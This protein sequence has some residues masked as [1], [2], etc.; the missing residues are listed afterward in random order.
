M[1]KITAPAEVAGWLVKGRVTVPDRVTGHMHRAEITA[2]CMPT[3]RPLTLLHA[4]GGFGKTTLLAECCRAEGARGVPTAWLFLDEQDDEAMLDTYLTF[5]FQRAGLDMAGSFAG[6]AG[7]REA[8]RRIMIALRAI[9]ADGRP[10]VLALDAV[11]RAVNKDGVSVLNELVRA[12]VANLHLALACRQLPV[13]LDIARPVFAGAEVITAG[14]LRFSRADIARFFG[15]RLS[16]QQLAQV[17][18]ESSGWPIALRVERESRGQRNAERAQVV[19]AVVKNWIESRLWCDLSDDDREFVLDAGILEWMDAEL[20]DEALGGQNLMA[21]LHSLPSL[22][23]LLEPVRG[24]ARKVWRLHEL[25]RQHCVS[26]RRR[27]MPGRYRSIHQR[28]AT[29]LARRGETIAAVR[30]AAEAA[31]TALL[32]LILT[33]AGGVQLLLRQGSDQLL[34]ADQSMTEETLALFPRLALVRI[35]ALLVK[36]EIGEAARQLA[37]ARRSLGAAAVDDAQLDCELHSV[38]GMLAQNSCESVGSPGVRRLMAGLA[39]L[40]DRPDVNPL[41]RAAMEYGL[42]MVHNLKAEFD[43]A[44]ERARCARRWIGKEST[45]LNMALDFQYGQVAMARGRVREAAAWYRKGVKA[46]RERFLVDSR[47]GVL[48]EVL[49]RELEL[50][51][52]RFRNEDDTLLPRA[53]WRAS[54]Q[55]ASHASAADMA[56]ELAREARG[57]D[58]A[59]EVAEEMS[60]VARGTGLPQLERYLAGLRVAV[61]AGAGR[62]DDA[63]ARWR[64]HALPESFDRCVDLAGQ[65][66]R[67]ME[68]LSC[69]RLRLCT[70]GGE[71]EAGRRLVGD[72]LA[73]ATQR[74]LRRTQMRALA[75]A[76]AHEHAAGEPDLAAEHLAT[77]LR[78][79]AETDYARPIVRERASAIPLLTRFLDAH[80]ASPL[81]NPATILLAAARAGEQDTVPM[82]TERELEVL[83]QLETRTD[84]RIAAAL[85]VTRA[86]VR[87]H[88]Q[89]LFAKL[90]VNGRHVAVERARSLGILPLDRSK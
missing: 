45:Y 40:A 21:R 27:D 19:G 17:A 16:R 68:L 39:R 1:T 15:G 67:E 69:A 2:R 25:L 14:D 34:A 47:F 70:A 75:Q 63:E 85:G 59:L 38:E 58:Y 35:A 89:R 54:T 8:G 90:G 78:L 42:S 51:R 81:A 65:S 11:E 22:A 56:V 44:L 13:G 18:Q 55:F 48:G 62:V 60:A 24:G 86:G 6:A 49:T 10:W 36:G 31:D 7:V 32:G 28:I 26:R 66:W 33:H 29:V 57:I 52:N 80:A 9:Q 3:R 46:A 72:L 5:A 88:V 82:L 74:G 73:V 23:G 30:H 71:F 43:P 41:G 61:L 37:A 4:P 12:N 84:H 79:F 20:L 50:E 83:R 53:L 77:F 64:D 76:M 87:Y